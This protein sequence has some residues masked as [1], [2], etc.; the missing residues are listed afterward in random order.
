MKKKYTDQDVKRINHYIEIIK[1]YISESGMRVDSLSQLALAEIEAS[2]GHKKGCFKTVLQLAKSG[3]LCFENL[4]LKI[5]KLEVERKKTIKHKYYFYIPLSFEINDSKKFSITIE[6]NAIYFYPASEV[7]YKE[8]L[9]NEEF[10][11][12]ELPREKKIHK[13]Q[14]YAMISVI[15]RDENEAFY[16]AMTI[17]NRMRAAF[18][19]IY[20]RNIDQQHSNNSVTQNAFLSP[21]WII[22]RRKS[23]WR[24][25]FII[26]SDMRS[27]MMR[28]YSKLDIHR[29]AKFA[30][31]LIGPD[32]SFKRFLHDI[33]LLYNEAR[34]LEYEHEAMLAYWRVLER[35]ALASKLGGRTQDVVSH[36]GILFKA[37][38]FQYPPLGLLKYMADARNEFVH[39]GEYKYR[40]NLDDINLVVKKIIELLV[41]FR[42][43]FDNEMQLEYFYKNFN[44]SNKHIESFT[45]SVKNIEK[46]RDLQEGEDKI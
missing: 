17:L 4:K 6:G 29:A 8:K 19:Y 36:I 44:L 21:Y 45:V 7:P 35:A 11:N 46:I 10:V 16:S 18:N 9:M 43:L 1:E 34:E 37:M 13:N 14:S 20:A 3:E 33:V 22:S 2:F 27:T 30:R 41:S 28:S 5:D 32:K 12:K 42:R 39:T 26:Q 38:N 15:E 23:N 31:L 40:Y 24:C 25:G